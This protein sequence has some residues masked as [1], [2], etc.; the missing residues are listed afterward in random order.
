LKLHNGVVTPRGPELAQMV[1]V[2]GPAAKNGDA[3]R[4]T[5]IVFKDNYVHVEINGGP[6]KKQKWYERISVGG[7]GGQTPVAPSDSNANARGSFV[8]VYFDHYVPEMTG[9]DFKQILRPVL[10]FDSKSVE[11]AYLETVPPKAK[12]AIENHQVLVGMNREMVTYAKGRPP[13]KVREK[14]DETEFEEWIY[15][16]PPKDVEFV[17]FI[18]DEVV[19]LET[20]KVDGTKL[21]KTD[22]ELELDP[23]TKVAK[24]QDEPKPTG[25]PTL[26]R[27]GEE[28]DSPVSHTPTAPGTTRRPTGVPDPG[29]TNSPNVLP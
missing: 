8:N 7:A 12:A 5:G 2:F 9:Q 28:S 16:E 15:G 6:V 10:D 19:R 21:V 22:K 29:P 4:I 14:E 11:E 18:G 1:S 3:V 25:T 20:M 26:R 24:Q 13:K 17:R 27:P 23:V